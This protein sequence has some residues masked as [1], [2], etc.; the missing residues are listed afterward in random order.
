MN[1][2]EVMPLPSTSVVPSGT[3]GSVELPHDGHDDSTEQVLQSDGVDGAEEY[4]FSSTQTFALRSGNGLIL[5]AI[6]F[7]ILIRSKQDC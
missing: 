3:K 4:A 2:E 5:Q 7:Q 6:I 1:V